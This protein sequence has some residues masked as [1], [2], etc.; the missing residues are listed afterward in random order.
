MGIIG[1]GY[2]NPNPSPLTWLGNLRSAEGLYFS[3]ILWVAN[4]KGPL[5]R[6]YPWNEAWEE[7]G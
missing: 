3:N 4:F 6:V 1:E 7:I 2:R 5:K